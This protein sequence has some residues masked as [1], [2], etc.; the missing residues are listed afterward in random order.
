MHTLVKMA[1]ELVEAALLEANL[2][3]N[4]LRTVCTTKPGPLARYIVRLLDQVRGASVDWRGQR[5]TRGQGSQE[6]RGEHVH[7]GRA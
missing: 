2:Q 4:R 3:L 7:G 6:D 5:L 1:I